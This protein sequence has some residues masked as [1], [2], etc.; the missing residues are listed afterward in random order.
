M[1]SILSVLLPKHNVGSSVFVLLQLNKA[2]SYIDG[3]FLYGNS[4]V[5]TSYLRD[6]NSG[7]LACQDKH[8]MYPLLNDVRLPFQMYPTRNK[9]ILVPETLWR[10]YTLHGL[11]VLAATPGPLAGFASCLCSRNG[12]ALYDQRSL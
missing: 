3:S 10:T 1:L 2:S 12:V 5:R 9:T 6:P 11:G 7:K 4:I 8:C